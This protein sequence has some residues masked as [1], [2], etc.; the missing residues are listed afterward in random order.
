MLLVAM[1]DATAPA[2][3]AG[4]ETID[5]R[6]ALPGKVAIVFDDAAAPAAQGALEALGYQSLQMVHVRCLCG[7]EGERGAGVPPA[8][9]KN[10]LPDCSE[11][12]ARLVAGEFWSTPPGASVA[13]SSCGPRRAIP[14][15]TA[16]S[17]CSI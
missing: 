2:E 13:L 6:L 7:A 17:I 3:S 1:L 15:T 5:G 16:G 12:T 10:P 9:M 11:D 14:T 4:V 8:I